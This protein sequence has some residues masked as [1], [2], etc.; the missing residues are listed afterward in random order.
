MNFGENQGDKKWHES[1][2]TSLTGLFNKT[3]TIE[4]TDSGII[5]TEMRQTAEDYKKKRPS[6]EKPVKRSGQKIQNGRV[7]QKMVKT[8]KIS[9]HF[10]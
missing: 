5:L 3:K 7:R 4:M 8:A 6:V 9:N 1:G 2:K 10:D